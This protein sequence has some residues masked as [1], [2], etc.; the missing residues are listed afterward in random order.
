[1]FLLVGGVGCRCQRFPRNPSSSTVGQRER[2]GESSGTL[3]KF[4]LYHHHRPVWVYPRSVAPYDRREREREWFI[5][6]GNRAPVSK[7]TPPHAD[8]PCSVSGFTN[9]LLP[10]VFYSSGAFCVSLISNGRALR[11]IVCER[12]VGVPDLPRRG[13]RES[14]HPLRATPRGCHSGKRMG[15]QEARCLSRYDSFCL[16]ERWVLFLFMTSGPCVQLRVST[17]TCF[18]THQAS[19]S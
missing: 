4:V 11:C 1:M 14:Q 13:K 7:A 15:R 9:N 5:Q 6:G 10:V 16:G 3:H 19:D 18:A 12:G 2:E 17:Q 8:A